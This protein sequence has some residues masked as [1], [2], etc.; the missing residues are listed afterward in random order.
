M[1]KTIEGLATME[2]EILQG[3]VDFVLVNTDGLVSGEVAV[4]YKTDL[5]KALKP[6]VIIGIQKQDE[7]APLIASLEIP[8]FSLNHHLLLTLE[9]QKN[10][11]TSEK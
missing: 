1:S 7:L 9:H 6:D 2:A 5:V 11:N 4:K 8:V 3:Q 10:A